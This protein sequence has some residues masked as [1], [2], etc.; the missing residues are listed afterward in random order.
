MGA[1]PDR[2]EEVPGGVGGRQGHA[3]GEAEYVVA[4]PA[5]YQPT[6]R[7]VGVTPGDRWVALSQRLVRRREARG[8][9]ARRSGLVSVD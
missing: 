2:L 9:I 5:G 4:G 6:Q 3:L 7:I 1:A 8:D